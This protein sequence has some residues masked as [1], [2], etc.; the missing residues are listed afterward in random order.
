MLFGLAMAAPNVTEAGASSSREVHDI[1]IYISGAVSGANDTGMYISGAVPWPFDS[2]TNIPRDTRNSIYA[3]VLNAT[4]TAHSAPACRLCL[5]DKMAILTWS[6]CAAVL[7]L[8]L[9]A[10]AFFREELITA[11]GTS[12]PGVVARGGSPSEAAPPDQKA[13]AASAP[14]A[15]SSSWWGG[16]SGQAPKESS[17]LLQR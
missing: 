1:D 13:T 16:A 10:F 5:I 14:A 7:I 9:F 15:Q 3:H 6:A 12:L 4:H 2:G 17:S 11:A 8:I